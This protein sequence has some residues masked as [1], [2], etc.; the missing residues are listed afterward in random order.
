MSNPGS[1]LLDVLGYS[2]S[3]IIVCIPG[4]PV[5]PIKEYASL[6]AFEQELA[7]RLRDDAYQRSFLRLI[8]HGDA[9]RF[10]G[11]L[12]SALQTLEW[13]PDAAHREQTLTGYRDGVY[14]RVY[15]DNPSL[16]LAESFL[17]AT[18]SASCT[19]GTRRGSKNPPRNWQCQPQRSIMM[20]GMHGW[21]TMPNGV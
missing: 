8:A 5:A 20:R 19:P 7:L 6:K 9:G 21:R 15:R 2:D 16:D 13:N 11:K 1:N 17:T 14:Q 3:R 10:L 4:D 18:C 12:Q